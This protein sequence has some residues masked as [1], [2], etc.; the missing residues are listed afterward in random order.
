MITVETCDSKD[1]WDDEVLQR[2]GH[3]LQLWGWGTTKA[4]HNWRVERVFV[5]EG[6]EILGAAQLLIRPL[7]K[8]FNALVYVPRGPVAA[9]KNREAVLEELAAYAKQAYKAVAISVEPDWA[10]MPEVRGWKKT[11]NTILIPETLILDLAK[12]EDE[13][14]AAMTKKTR[15]YIRKSQ[16][17][18]IEI[19]KVKSREELAACLDI[20]R[21]TAE[22]AGFGIHD[23][24]YYYDIY[25]EL[26]EHSPVFAAFLGEKPVAFLWLAISQETAFELY[27]GMD[28]DGQRLR[29]NYALKW[30]A[31]ATTKKWGIARYDFNGLLNDGVST[32]K[33]GFADHEDLLAGTYDK[34]LSPLYTLWSQAL[35]TAKRIVRK[36]KNR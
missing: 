24:K 26:G 32:F 6:T 15:Q 11:S 18:A 33:R 1:R 4:A 7:P 14:M 13:L 29:A 21:Q 8:P 23:D 22:R 9:K 25:D 36:L 34:P 28:D 16:G 2:G 17:E 10:E 20:Y 30:Y 35:P 3:P 19:R 27:G 5:K 12:S 31:I